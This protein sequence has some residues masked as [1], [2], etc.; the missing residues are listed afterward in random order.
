MRR[1]VPVNSFFVC[2]CMVGL[3][4]SV[5]IPYVLLA[6]FFTAS[7]TLARSVFDALLDALSAE[8]VEA[9]HDDRVAEALVAHLAEDSLLV[10]GGR[11][12]GREEGRKGGRGKEEEER[13]GEEKKKKGIKD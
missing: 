7:G 1:N 6:E 3:N 11:G 12:E 13:R 2:V 8:G 9:L 4:D 10:G 5:Q